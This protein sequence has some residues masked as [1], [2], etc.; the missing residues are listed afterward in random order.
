M[1]DFA[2][3]SRKKPC[4]HE[5]SS[6]TQAAVA[7]SWVYRQGHT[8]LRDRQNRQDKVNSVKK[9]NGQNSFGGDPS[10]RL[11]GSEISQ[12]LCFASQ[13]KDNGISD[14]RIWVKFNS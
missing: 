10:P 1:N 5:I 2:I 11:I 3:L 9:S 7:N 14:T 13:V 4:H 6:R 8:V 12:I